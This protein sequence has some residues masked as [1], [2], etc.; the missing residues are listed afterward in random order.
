MRQCLYRATDC[1]L[2]NFVTEL[3][4]I[5]FITKIVVE[6]E[7]YEIR[8]SKQ[9]LSCLSFQYSRFSLTR[10]EE[11]R[12]NIDSSKAMIRMF[13]IYSGVEIS[14]YHVRQFTPFCDEGVERDE[15]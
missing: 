15:K 10:E 9:V 7:S 14:W 2:K 4:Q 1:L 12:L 3:I 6:T 11:A 5:R 8:E 13:S